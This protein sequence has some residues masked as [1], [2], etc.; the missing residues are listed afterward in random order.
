MHS[1]P[2]TAAL[3]LRAKDGNDGRNKRFTFIAGQFEVI[4]VVAC[5][6]AEMDPCRDGVWNV[7]WFIHWC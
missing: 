7:Y 2:G 5:G 4:D 3:T 6:D 1:A